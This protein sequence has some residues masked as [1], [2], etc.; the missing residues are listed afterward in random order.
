LLWPKVVTMVAGMENIGH[1]STWGMR[2]NN[3]MSP[4]YTAFIDDYF[5]CFGGIAAN[6]L[7]IFAL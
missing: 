2:G 7:L 3:P 5:F 6:F 4:I 1:N